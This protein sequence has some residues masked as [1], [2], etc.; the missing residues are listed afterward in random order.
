MDAYHAVIESSVDTELALENVTDE[1]AFT[2]DLT[3]MV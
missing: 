3:G 2:D 1:I